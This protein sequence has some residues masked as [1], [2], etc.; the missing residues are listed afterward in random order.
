MPDPAGQNSPPFLIDPSPS[1]NPQ[2]DWGQFGLDA[3]STGLDLAGNVISTGYQNQQNQLLAQDQRQ[4][5]KSQSQWQN[6]KNIEF[7]QMQAQY[8]ESRWAANNKYNSPIEQMARLKE[9]GLN[10][11]LM[12][13]QG[14]VGNSGSPSGANLGSASDVKGYSRAESK[15]VLAGIQAFSHNAQLRN[16]N[17]QT[18]NVRAIQNVNIQE[19]LN[20]KTT[21]LQQILALGIDKATK[22]AMISQRM[23]ESQISAD[24][25]SISSQT[26]QT[27][28]KT[29]EKELQR[30]KASTTIEE[31]KIAYQKMVANF[32]ED[33]IHVG[34]NKLFRAM[35]HMGMFDGASGIWKEFQQWL[36]SKIPSSI[37]Q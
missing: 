31:L 36:K 28:V 15:N 33:G 22:K 25:A 18:D 4:W 34:D 30:L 2:F 9:A 7:W 11:H 5:N 17:A 23:S 32:A 27:R 29:I 10:P 1:A 37:K 14:T 24:E 12:Y 6:Q 8:N 26:V 3:L 13:G 16:L 21:G 19:A 20:K 35:S